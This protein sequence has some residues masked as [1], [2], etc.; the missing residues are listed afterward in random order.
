MEMAGVFKPVMKWQCL[1]PVEKQQVCSHQAAGMKKR[2]QLSV[3]LYIVKFL[4]TI[5]L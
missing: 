3:K 4:N 5:G 1:L 2:I